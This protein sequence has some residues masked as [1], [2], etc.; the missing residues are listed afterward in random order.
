MGTV[1]DSSLWVDYFRLKTPRSVKEQVIQFANDEEAVLCEPI[2]FEILRATLRSE[3]KRVEEVF[4]T[5]PLLPSPA[6]TWQQAINL[7]QQCLDAGILPR[8]MDL[9]ITTV[10]VHHGVEIVTF[11]AHFA[12]IAKVCSLKVHLLKRAASVA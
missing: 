10:C 5:L 2:R 4:A 7:G 9:L 12:E 11:D 3:R 1:I 8:A 6:G